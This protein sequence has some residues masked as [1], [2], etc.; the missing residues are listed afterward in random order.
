MAQRLARLTRCGEVLR[1]A[2]RSVIDH[3]DQTFEGAQSCHSSNLTNPSKSVIPQLL[4]GGAVTA[5][6][7]LT[8]VSC[9]VRASGRA[10]EIVSTTGSVLRIPSDALLRSCI[11]VGAVQAS[12]AGMRRRNT[13]DKSSPAIDTANA[14]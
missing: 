1:A 3:G 12:Q 7:H 14:G 5:R 13:F 4:A 11:A 8:V 2:D 6:I 10:F 9:L